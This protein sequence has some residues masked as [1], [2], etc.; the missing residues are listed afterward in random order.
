M[1]PFWKSFD[2]VLQTSNSTFQ[3]FFKDKWIYMTQ[4]TVDIN[5]SS[6]LFTV[7][8]NRKQVILLA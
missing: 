6:N 2:S 7:D 3:V 8:S 1:M 4:N 5:N